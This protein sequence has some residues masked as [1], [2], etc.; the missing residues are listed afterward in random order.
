MYDRISYLLF[1]NIIGPII[2]NALGHSASYRFL[3]HAAANFTNILQ[4]AFFQIPF[5]KKMQT[6]TDWKYRKAALNTFVWS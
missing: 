5:T 6:H 1:S 4:A 2:L 3:N